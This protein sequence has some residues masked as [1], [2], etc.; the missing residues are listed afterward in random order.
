[1]RVVLVVDP[2]RDDEVFVRQIAERATAGLRRSGHDV[3]VVDL[4]AERFWPVMSADDRRSYFSDHPLTC[5]ETAAS[6]ALVRRADGLVFAYPT[7]LSTVP[8][9]LKGWIERVFVPGVAFTIGDRT[10]AR[11]GLSNIRRL[12]G[13]TVH[14][15]ARR[16]VMRH[17]DNG[18][19]LV[20][21]NI[22]LCGGLRTTTRWI[23]MYG[24]AAATDVERSAFLDDVERRMARR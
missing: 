6:A 7:T 15:D 2:M 10:G 13:I 20:C 5:V 22:R 16:D 23:A 19:R 11:R 8:P 17:G 4:V 24:G 21:R 9:G 3:D 18:R 12:T 1:M 14:P